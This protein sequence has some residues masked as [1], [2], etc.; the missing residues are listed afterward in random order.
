MKRFLANEKSLAK[1]DKLDE[2]QGVLNEYVTL[3]HTEK[4]P[5][6]QLSDRPNYF[7]P[8]QGVF[9]DSSSTTKCRA[10]FDASA[11]HLQDSAQ[12][13]E[14]IPL[15]SDILI[16]FRSHKLAITADI[17]KMFREVWLDPADR[18]LHRFFLRN[19][20]GRLEEHRMTRLT[21]GVRTSPFIATQV[22]RQLADN[23]ETSHPI[24]AQIIRVNFYVDNLL[25][26][27]DTIEDANLIRLQLSNLLQ[28]AGMK[29]RKW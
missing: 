10:V 18:D 2:F 17:L 14:S 8:V 7:L 23:C 16:K 24:A 21:F 1:K 12:L 15:L 26:G 28:S 11:K 20:Q 13:S 4:V 25:S 5:R 3:G 29:L 6:H 9:K 22:L 19:E 27:T